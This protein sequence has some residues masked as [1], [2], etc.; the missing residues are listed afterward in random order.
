MAEGEWDVRKEACYIVCNAMTTGKDDEVQKCAEGG[1]IKGMCTL[2]QANDVKIIL[3]VLESIEVMLKLGAKRGTTAYTDALE[4]E[5]GIDALENLQEHE[6]NDVYEKAAAIVEM[7]FGDEEEY[8]DM[9]VEVVGRRFNPFVLSSPV[10]VKPKPRRGVRRRRAAP[11]HDGDDYG[12][13]D[14]VRNV[15]LPSALKAKKKRKTAKMTG[16]AAGAGGGSDD[17]ATHKRCSKCEQLKPLDGFGLHKKQGRS[18]RCKDCRNVYQKKQREA[19]EAKM[20]DGAE[21][22]EGGNAED[23]EGGEGC[24]G[25]KDD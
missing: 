10:A 22:E 9:V 25:G 8:E 12:D 23:V 3:V 21:R 19:R 18:P 24:E 17:A 2:L 4:E 1:A 13:D 5:G 11:R 16:K 15:D 7:Y 6:N 14:D 20:T